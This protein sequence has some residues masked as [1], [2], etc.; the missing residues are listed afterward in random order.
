[1]T[2]WKRPFLDLKSKLVTQY[3][4]GNEIFH[5]IVLS[6]DHAASDLTQAISGLEP[7]CMSDRLDRTIEIP[8]P[9]CQ[10]HAHMFWGGNEEVEALRKSLIGIF[11]SVRNIPEPYLPKLA[12]PLG[13]GQ[14]ERDLVLWS[15]L[16]YHL[17]WKFEAWYLQAE[18]E[19]S[20]SVDGR[21]YTAWND[22]P[23]SYAFD[24]R[25]AILCVQGVSTPNAWPQLIE[26]EEGNVPAMIVAYLLGD[27]ICGGFIK[28]SLAAVDIVLFQLD[29]PGPVAPKQIK[30]RRPSAKRNL[31]LKNDELD[32]IKEVRRLHV[33]QQIAEPLTQAQMAIEL[34]W[35][36]DP[37]EGKERKALLSRVHRAAERLFPEGGW[38]QYLEM[39]AA[40]PGLPGFAD[41]LDN[42]VSRVQNELSALIES[43]MSR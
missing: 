24:P 28:A 41:I 42:M 25:D 4:S 11:S 2:E 26:R 27:P 13:M 38:N 8:S 3:E 6:L 30:S 33:Y 31:R 23:G 7:A 40:G 20:G 22:W 37:K 43:E 19:C 1:M 16:V 14:A 35:V 15:G 5:A 34:A 32:L 36:T 12:V 9:G 10:L 17:A 29:Q 39:V 18:V 21:S